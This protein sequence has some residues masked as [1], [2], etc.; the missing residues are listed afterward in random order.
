MACPDATLLRISKYGLDPVTLT[1]TD[2]FK[3]MREFCADPVTFI[4]AML[5]E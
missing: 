3:L 4:E 5:E 2:H 1:D